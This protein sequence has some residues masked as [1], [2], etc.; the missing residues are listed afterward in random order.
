MSEISIQPIISDSDWTRKPKRFFEGKWPVTR[1]SGFGSIVF[2]EDGTDEGGDEEE[3]ENGGGGVAED[4]LDHVLR[5]FWDED[6]G[7][8]GGGDEGSGGGDSAG[9]GAGGFGVGN[10]VGVPGE[11]EAAF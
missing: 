2:M 8:N 9:I 11:G 10:L 7:G 6:G 4:M 1:Q 3:G 5:L